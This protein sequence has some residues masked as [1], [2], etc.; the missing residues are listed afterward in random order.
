M[1]KKYSAPSVFIFDAGDCHK[2]GHTLFYGTTGA[3]KTTFM[4]SLVAMSGCGKKVNPDEDPDK[5][6]E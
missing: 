6:P 4:A 1:T 2:R 3:G 5:D